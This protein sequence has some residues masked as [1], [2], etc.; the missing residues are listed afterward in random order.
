M[1]LKHLLGSA[2]IGDIIYDAP[3]SKYTSFRT[4]GRADALV[5]PKS[6]KELSRAIL[7]ARE[8]GVPYCVIG[9]GSN[10]LVRDGGVRGIVIRLAEGFSGIQVEGNT[11]TARA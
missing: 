7:L 11:V 8:N 5:M 9:N 2:L 1:E 6:E 4:G 3:M 10:L